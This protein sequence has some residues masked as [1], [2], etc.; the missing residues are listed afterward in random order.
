MQTTVELDDDLLREAKQKARELGKSLDA[1][2][3]AALRD[4][5]QWPAPVPLAEQVNDV[6][7]ALEASD[8]FFAALEEIR[9]KGC[10]PTPHRKV[11]LD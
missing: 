6:A 4:A 11:E 3:E 9:A 5:V 7:E 8:P 1:L 10:L 2:L